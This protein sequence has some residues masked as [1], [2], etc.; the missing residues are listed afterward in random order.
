[1]AETDGEKVATQIQAEAERL[2]MMQNFE[3]FK[4]RRA[5]EIS[6]YRRVTRQHTGSALPFRMSR[7]TFT[8]AAEK[9]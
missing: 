3:L 7:V 9:S 5:Q 2:S 8:V 1:M 6:R 4:A